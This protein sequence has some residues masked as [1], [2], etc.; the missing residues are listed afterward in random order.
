MPVECMCCSLFCICISPPVHA[1]IVNECKHRVPLCTF[2]DF[3]C[4]ICSIW[5]G[6]KTDRC[7]ELFPLKFC[8]PRKP[9]PQSK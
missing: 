8:L 6:Y 5:F 1:V 9:D 4:S 2:S 3:Q 7:D